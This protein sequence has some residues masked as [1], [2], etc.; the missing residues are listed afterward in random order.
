[1]NV[2]HV[3]NKIDR[4]NL[5]NNT[6]KVAYKLLSANGEWVPRSALSKVARSAAARVRD[7]RKEEFGAFVVDCASASELNRRGTK[8]TY[9]YRIRPGWVTKRQVDAVFNKQKNKGKPQNKFYGFFIFIMQK[10]CRKCG[11][12]IS[13]WRARA[14]VCSPCRNIYRQTHRKE[15][16]VVRLKHNLFHDNKAMLEAVPYTLVELKKHLESQFEPWMNWN[17]YG[18]YN[19]IR[20]TW[21]IDHIIPKSLLPYEKTNESNFVQLW[22][23]VFSYGKRDLGII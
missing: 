22:S 3:L 2:T 17:N 21:Q 7:L 8:S 13:G 10:Y 14:G 16:V 15:N 23:L 11:S 1:M 4:R 19:P 5:T 9:F 20:R 6:Q 18:R 12:T